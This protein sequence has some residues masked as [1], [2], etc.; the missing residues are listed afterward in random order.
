MNQHISLNVHSLNCTSYLNPNTPLIYLIEQKP[1]PPM[2]YISPE[3]RENDEKVLALL[4]EKNIDFN[5]AQRCL[6]KLMN[7]AKKD[8]DF[9]GAVL[10]IEETVEDD[11]DYCHAEILLSLLRRHGSHLAPGS[12]LLDL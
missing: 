12:E 3:H 5:R 6:A 7:K 1:S 2:L 8:R 9:L 10:P 11:R 4:R